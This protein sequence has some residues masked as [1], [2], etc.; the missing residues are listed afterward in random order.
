M[1]SRWNFADKLEAK[2][3]CQNEDCDAA[4][5]S[6]DGETQLTTSANLDCFG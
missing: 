1:E 4:N 2:E 6:S 5:K 3:N